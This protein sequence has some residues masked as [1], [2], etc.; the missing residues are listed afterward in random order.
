MPQADDNLI[1][2]LSDNPA[3]RLSWS[4]TSGALPTFRTNS[5]R[6]YNIGREQWMTP[7]D[8]LS[9]L[10][11]PVTPAASLAMGVPILPVP[12]SNFKQL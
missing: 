12:Q 3:K 10:G 8:R 1:I 6:F 5:T 7:R 9:A 2:N 4:G 11:L